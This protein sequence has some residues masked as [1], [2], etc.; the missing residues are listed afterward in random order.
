MIFKANIY[1]DKVD[2]VQQ[3]LAKQIK[4]ASEQIVK[5]ENVRGYTG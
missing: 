2:Q 5:E 1:D 4:A 3:S